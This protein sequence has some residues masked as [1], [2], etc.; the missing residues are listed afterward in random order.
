LVDSANRVRDVGIDRSVSKDM[1]RAE[2]E[3]SRE[4]ER[5]RTSYARRGSKVAHSHGERRSLGAQT[6]IQKDRSHLVPVKILTP[7][8]Q[9][10]GG[11]MEEEE[12]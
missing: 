11:R 8:Q 1:L 12:E 6:R 10:G 4:R 2:D 9:G 5:E 3:I 7:V